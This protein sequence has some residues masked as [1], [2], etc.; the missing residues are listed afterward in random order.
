MSVRRLAALLATL[1]GATAGPAG[2]ANHELAVA[3]IAS[4]RFNVACTNIAQDPALIAQFGG[5]PPE[6]FWEGKPA[7]GQLRYIS[8]ILAAPGTAVRFDVPVPD[9]SRLYPQFADQRVDH[10]AIVCHPTPAANADPGYVLPQT[11]SVVPHMQPAGTAPKLIGKVEY[12]SAYGIQLSP[13]PPPGPARLPMIVFSHGLAGSPI[14]PGHL[15]ALVE[16][17]SQG[18][19]VAAV[20]HGDARFSRIRLDNISDYIFL[21]T[22]FD[23]FVEMELMRPL[24]LTAMIDVML[25]HPGFAGAID[26]DR[27][28][29]FGAS[30]GGQAVANLVGAKLTTSLGLACRATARDARVKAVVGLVPYAGQSFLPAFCDDQAGADEV[31]A[32]FLA[33]AGTADLT[34]PIGLTRQA[35]NRMPSSHYLVE[36]VGVPHEY[37]DEYRGDIFTWT[38][39]FL[40]AYLH[41]PVDSQAMARLIRMKSV[42]GG[43]P[44]N[45]TV[46]V[47]IPFGANAATEWYAVE[48]IKAGGQHYFIPATQS[49]VMNIVDGGAGPGWELTGEFFKVFKGPTSLYP[50]VVPVCRFSSATAGGVNTSHFF[51]ASA[52]ECEMVKNAGGWFYEGIAFHARAVMPDGRCPDGWLAVQR[53]YNNGAAQNNSNHRFTTSDSS[54]RDMARFGWALEGNVMC[55]L[56]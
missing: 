11:G 18:Y 49:E 3:P 48:F 7:N 52:A 54:W 24:S 42:N 37:R 35:I 5:T 20:F 25:A 46:D 41:V 10:V 4:G 9:D 45:L 53:A 19:I 21:F 2:A 27:I 40:N 36:L 47:H 51:T 55:A 28:G 34:A 29:A 23:R 44:D 12:A 56:P 8:Q 17:A 38:V 31:W 26:A 43:P 14:S 22:Q 33:L 39:T 32:P 16:L 13:I 30:M 1:A 15:E 6:D 50:S